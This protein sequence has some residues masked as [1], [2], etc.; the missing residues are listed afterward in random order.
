MYS[1][2]FSKTGGPEVLKYEKLS[3]SEPKDNEV[4]IK[5]S[6][7]GLNFIDTYH[8]SGLYPVPLP[9]GIGLEGSGTIEKVGPGVKGFKEGD[10]VAYAAAPIG[11]Y[12]THRIYPTK[13]LVKIPEGIDPEIV[14]CLMT[15]GLTTF[16]LLHKTFPVKKGQTVLFHAAAGGVGQIFCQWAKSLGCEVIG[17]VG[18]EEKIKLAKKYGCDEVINYSK[19][20]FQER[21]MEITKNEGL[22]VVYDGVG[23]NTLEK[24]LGCLKMRGTMVSFGNASGKLDPI[25]V[26]KLI[27]PKGLYLTRPSIAH[28]TSTRSELDEAAEKLFEMVKSNKVKIEIFKKYSLKDASEAH[29]DLE[30]RKILGP[31]VIIP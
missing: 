31:A 5:H 10:K 13:N 22:P 3:I 14:A 18:S 11:S 28:Y 29:K 7:I 27:A 8:R 6:A 1:I 19:D 23:K 12:A 21:V 25:D 16:Y 26:G 2:N 24:S 30:E 4:L 15:K 17:T 20:N 9:S